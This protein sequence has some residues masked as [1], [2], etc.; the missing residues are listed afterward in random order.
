MQRYSDVFL[1]ISYNQS[2][3]GFE[4]VKSHWLYDKYSSGVL[5]SMLK[6]NE[7]PYPNVFSLSN[8]LPSSSTDPISI[9]ILFL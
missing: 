8:S 9:L 6:R 5:F 3:R 7:L 4:R 2:W 1:G